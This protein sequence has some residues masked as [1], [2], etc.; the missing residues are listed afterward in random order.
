MPGKLIEDLITLFVVLDPVGSIPIFLNATARLDPRDRSKVALISIV[1]AL[2]V[3]MLF[4]YCGQYALEAMHISIPAF[5]IAGAAVLFLFA[6]Q[7]IF[8]GHHASGSAEER[9]TPAEVAI[10]PVAMPGIA[11]PGALLAV[12]LLTDN[13]R[14]SFGEESVTAGLTV[15]VLLIVLVLLLLA[16][17]IQRYLGAAG[18]MV[19]TQIMGLVL[20]AFSVQQVLDG[21]LDVFVHGAH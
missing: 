16:S 21:V 10:F 20:A 17:R 14:F 19:I 12:V 8:G 2:L 5:R 11:S 15:A 6:L 4:L 7:M 18:I 3:L 1:V 13:N 9:R